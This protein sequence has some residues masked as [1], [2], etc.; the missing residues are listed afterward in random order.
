MVPLDELR[1][2]LSDVPSVKDAVGQLS[3]DGLA[4]RLGDRVGVTRASVR[5]RQL[6]PI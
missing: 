2:T 1:S 3:A 4:S 6:G 5:F